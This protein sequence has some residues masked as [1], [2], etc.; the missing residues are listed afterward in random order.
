MVAV[1]VPTVVGLA[2]ER[3]GALGTEPVVKETASDQVEPAEL[4]ARTRKTY[5][6]EALRLVS[7]IEDCP[8]DAIP[9]RLLSLCQALMLVP[10]STV[11][12]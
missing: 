12:W 8:S 1:V 11:P 5:E 6:V 3:A 10:P 4:V 2:T 9:L 7:P